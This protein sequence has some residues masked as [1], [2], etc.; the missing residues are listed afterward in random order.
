MIASGDA[1]GCAGGI[2]DRCDLAFGVEFEQVTIGRA[3]SDSATGCDAAGGYLDQID[4]IGGAA[5]A[6]DRP[7]F[8]GGGVV[9]PPE[10]LG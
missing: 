9:L 1:D 8:A 7:L 3:G 4:R 6:D 2:N 5:D 10:D